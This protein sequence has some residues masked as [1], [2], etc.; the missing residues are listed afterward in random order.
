MVKA[1]EFI[2]TW[3]A[4]VRIKDHNGALIQLKTTIQ[5]SNS[6]TAR[7]LLQ[8]QYGKESVMS[9]PKQIKIK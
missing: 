2:K 9:T 6:A 4:T 5:A 8:A 1:T 3:E 7:R